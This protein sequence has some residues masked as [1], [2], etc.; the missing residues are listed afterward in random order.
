[1]QIE[2]AQI[3]H[4]QRILGFTKL[5]LQQYVSREKNAKVVYNMLNYSA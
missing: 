4:H 5:D 3:R 1:M 2:K